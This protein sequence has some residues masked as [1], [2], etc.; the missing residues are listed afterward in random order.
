MSK[1]DLKNIRIEYLKDTKE[2]IADFVKSCQLNWKWFGPQL[3]AE[4]ANYDL[5]FDSDGYVDAGATYNALP[6]RG[7]ALLIITTSSRSKIGGIGKHSWLEP[8]LLPYC[9]LVPLFLAAHKKH[10]NVPYDKWAY[11]KKE[12]LK[13]FVEAKLLEAMQDDT[14]YPTK[15]VGM[16]LRNY[17]IVRRTGL[18]VSSSPSTIWGHVDPDYPPEMGESTVVAPRLVQ[19]IQTQ[20]WAAH[21]LN[22]NSSMIL[23]NNEW[24]DIPQPF[25]SGEIFETGAGATTPASGRPSWFINDAPDEEDTP[26]TWSAKQAPRKISRINNPTTPPKPDVPWN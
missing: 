13:K 21:P 23:N 14:P 10:N 16:Y 5:I 2:T 3:L 1:F 17:F 8:D 24:D 19:T 20:L 18:P 4:I 25:D 26:A 12:D 6:A 7:R 22:R 15:E 9:G 11:A